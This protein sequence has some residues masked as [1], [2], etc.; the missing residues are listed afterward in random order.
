M[1]LREACVPLEGVSPWREIDDTAH[2]QG[3]LRRLWGF[4]HENAGGLRQ[5]AGR[6]PRHGSAAPERGWH[7]CYFH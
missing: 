2:A 7:F 3:F 1:P 5:Y 4:T 6:R